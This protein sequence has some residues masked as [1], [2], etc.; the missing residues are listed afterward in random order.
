MFRSIVW[1]DSSLLSL[2]L[3]MSVCV[4]LWFDASHNNCERILS[5]TITRNML[6]KCIVYA[7]YALHT[8]TYAEHCK[9]V[10]I[11]NIRYVLEV[12]IIGPS[13]SNWKLTFS[14]QIIFAVFYQ[15]DISEIASFVLATYKSIIFLKIHIFDHDLCGTDLSL[16]M[17][18]LRTALKCS[19]LLT[20]GM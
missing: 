6:N 18:R 9:R 4:C 19:Y 2:F 16:I 15:M 3:S 5:D 20:L 11:L 7:S 14:S 12:I 17:D 1:L 8:I 10:A 13:T